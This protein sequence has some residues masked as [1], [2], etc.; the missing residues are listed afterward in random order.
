MKKNEIEI[1][2]KELEILFKILE[3]KLMRLSLKYQ[4]TIWDAEDA[5]SET[6][7][8]VLSKVELFEGKSTLSTWVYSIC[9]N[10]NLEILR[11]KKT[12]FEHLKKYFYFNIVQSN[13][14]D[15]EYSL[16]NKD[17]Q[18]ALEKL[19]EDEKNVFLLSVYEELPQKEI[20]EILN[21]TV[22]NV[23]VKLH[24]GRKKLMVTLG[25]YLR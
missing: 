21:M 25:D 14:V 17:F 7:V 24:R 10:K 1:I 2:L 18:K 15:N 4:K 19:D 23:K 22:S 13:D 16:L 6:M 5:V 11:K 12:Y 20:A 9:I 3:P 8:Q